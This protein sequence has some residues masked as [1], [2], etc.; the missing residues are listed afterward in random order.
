MIK[1]HTTRAVLNVDYLMYIFTI[2]IRCLSSAKL[3]IF[4]RYKRNMYLYWNK[5]YINKDYIVFFGFEWKDNGIIS[6]F[7]KQFPP[8]HHIL[9]IQIRLC[10]LTFWYCIWYPAY[11]H[12]NRMHWILSCRNV[13]RNI[14]CV[15]GAHFHKLHTISRKK[16]NLMKYA[17]C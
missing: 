3:Y 1:T 16:T 12:Q 14:S 11:V 17:F 5:H 15:M 4:L 13:N 2:S 6:I 9:C 10:I 8:T 7:I